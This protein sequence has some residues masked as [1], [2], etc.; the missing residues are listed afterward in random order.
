MKRNSIMLEKIHKGLFDKGNIIYVIVGLIG[1]ALIILKKG[2]DYFFNYSSILLGLFIPIFLFI[3]F[4][5]IGRQLVQKE[6]IKIQAI[7]LLIFYAA[8]TLLVFFLGLTNSQAKILIII[9]SILCGAILLVML[10]LTYRDGRN[11]T[12][13]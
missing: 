4:Y 2:W 9:D 11:R 6:P 8:L 1:F 10:Y 12:E 3:D 13:V 7:Y 5:K